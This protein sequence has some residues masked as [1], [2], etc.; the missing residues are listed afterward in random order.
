VVEDYSKVVDQLF[1][2][3]MVC[4]NERLP[5]TRQKLS[6]IG[7]VGLKQIIMKFNSAT[8]AQKRGGQWRRSAN[9]GNNVGPGNMEPGAREKTV[10]WNHKS[11]HYHHQ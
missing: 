2:D 7:L 6:K 8:S 9:N 4:M 11:F 1:F 3:A 10:V 5:T